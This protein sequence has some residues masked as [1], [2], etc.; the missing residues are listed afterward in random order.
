[1]AGLKQ[2]FVL[3]IMLL[4]LVQAVIGFAS[5]QHYAAWLAEARK[6]GWRFQPQP[7]WRR[8]RRQYRLAGTTPQGAVWELRRVQRSGVFLFRWVTYDKPLPYGSLLLLPQARALAEPK[9]RDLQPVQLE[10][11]SWQARFLLLATHQRLGERYVGV[12]VRHFLHMWPLW[13]QVGALEDVQWNQTR[14]LINGRFDRNWETIDRIVAL[15]TAL[16]EEAVEE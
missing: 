3:L 2:I 16:V 1:M 7:W 4:L 11:V 6:R 14:L 15:G 9:Q 10:D 5:Q 13:P 8:W 12:A